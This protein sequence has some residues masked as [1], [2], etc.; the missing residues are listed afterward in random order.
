MG[1]GPAPRDCLVSLCQAAARLTQLTDDQLEP[2]ADILAAAD[3]D[4]WEVVDLTRP[5]G[6]ANQTQEIR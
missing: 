2:Y 3:A 1:R 5:D 4:L 6:P